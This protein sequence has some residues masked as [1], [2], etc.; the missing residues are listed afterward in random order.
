MAVTVVTMVD[1]TVAA[2][3][4]AAEGSMAAAIVK[5]N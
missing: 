5:Y 4:M 3:S 1:S 2:A